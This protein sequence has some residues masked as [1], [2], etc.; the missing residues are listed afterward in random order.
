MRRSLSLLA[1]LLAVPNLAAPS[2]PLAGD[3]K[4][5]PAAARPRIQVSFKLDPRLSGP[6]YGGERW[7]SPPTYR[8]ASAQD[9][10]E[11][12]ASAV[13]SAGRPLEADLEWTVSD[14]E[15]VSVAP[16]RGEHVKITV[17]RAGESVVT[18]KARGASRKLTVK[19]V[20]TNGIR[21]VIISQ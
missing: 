10:V 11:A 7:V 14:P 6:T 1:V 2:S 20:E 13:D 18:V 12:R 17:K 3:E 19:A 21:Q 16:P 8:G 4:E 15:R 5:A 9:T